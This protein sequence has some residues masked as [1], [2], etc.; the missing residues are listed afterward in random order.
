MLYFPK[1][2]IILILGVCLLGILFTLPNMLPAGV[3][4]KIPHWLPDQQV[5]LGLDLRGGSYLLL[6][7]D[8][9]ALTKDQLENLVENVR[10]TL[11]KARIGYKGLGIV[12]NAVQV[13]IRD[14]ADTARADKLLQ[15]LVTPLTGGLFSGRG[16]TDI[17]V[18]TTAD[19]T[20]TLTPT[21][22]AIDQRSRQAVQ[23]SIAIVRRRIDATGINE[24]EIQ[25]Q[26]SNQILVQLPGL[27]DPT[28]VKR[29]L[30]KTARLTFQLIDTSPAADSGQVPPGDE[31]LYSDHNGPNGKPTPYVVRRQISV[32][33]AD[34]TDAQATF[35]NQT[36]EPVVSFRLN[37]LGAQRFA[38]VTRNNVGKPF[39][40]VLDNK[41]ISAPVIRE[42]ILGGS[43]QISGNFTT[44][45]ANDLAILLRAGALPAPLRVV[46][47]RT[48][49]PQ[50]GADSIRSGI[51]ASIIGFFLVVAYMTVSYGLF[52]LFANAAL[53]ANLFLILGVMSVLQATL[54]L[55]GIAGILLTT[56][57]AVDANVLINERIREEY[58]LG[59]SPLAAMEAGFARAF[60]TIFD[61][62]IT[63]LIKMA[64]LF[65]LGSGP[66]RGFAVT[67]SIGILTSLFTAILLTRLLM[68]YWYR[69]RRPAALP[70]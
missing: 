1:W 4:K 20:V 64:I 28:R 24:P 43:G 31:I 26:G 33:G 51:E 59:K 38:D 46:E 15:E 13:T 35:D 57:M 62:N 22:A 63:T 32:S 65:A 30:G 29:L 58:L 42:P 40:I 16:D 25:R 5:R 19:G 50:L 36:G 49:G 12:N 69:R 34:L 44:Q 6:Q 53:I 41:V 8:V 7:V 18:A 70:V 37:G 55:P 67:I 9:N 66:V 45:S 14:A 52:G 21:Q 11:A 54:T 23:Q 60:T 61:S 39:A 56:G 48:V 10:Q 3:V 17:T 2:K 47:E 27:K 68:V